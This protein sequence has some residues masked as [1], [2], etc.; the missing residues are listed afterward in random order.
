MCI[1]HYCMNYFFYTLPAVRRKTPILPPPRR[2]TAGP[3]LREESAP[4]APDPERLSAS[5]CQYASLRG[6]GR[7]RIKRVWWRTP[8]GTGRVPAIPVR[9]T[10]RIRQNSARIRAFFARTGGVVS[11]KPLMMASGLGGRSG[12]MRYGQNSDD[13]E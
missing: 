4:R 9:E 2:R 12:G 11:H 10:E 6:C 13:E 5:A 8:A 7:C 1:P 3:S